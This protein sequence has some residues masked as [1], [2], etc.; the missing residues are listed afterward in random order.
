MAK[1]FLEAVAMAMVARALGVGVMRVLEGWGADDDG[2]VSS[3]G[4]EAS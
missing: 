2:G 4:L 3:A 1:D